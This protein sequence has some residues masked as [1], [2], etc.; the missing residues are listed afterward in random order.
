MDC[1]KAQE[2]I[3]EYVLDPQSLG[4]GGRREIERHVASCRECKKVLR[5]VGLIVSAIRDDG[6]IHPMREESP[7]TQFGNR[8]RKCAA[9][10][11]ML[12]LIAGLTVL[13]DTWARMGERVQKLPVSNGTV[14]ETRSGIIRLEGG[15]TLVAKAGADFAVTPLE[16][17]GGQGHLVNLK[18][19]EL[20]IEVNHNGKPFDVVTSNARAVITGTRFDIRSEG[21]RTELVLVDGEVKFSGGGGMVLVREGRMSAVSGRSGPSAPRAVDSRACV[22]WAY[23]AL[24]RKALAYVNARPEWALLHALPDSLPASVPMDPASLEY[25]AWRD[26]HRAWFQCHFPW[27]FQAESSLNANA[28]FEGDYLDLLMV[29]GD[30]LQFRR[31]AEGER[32]IAVFDPESIRRLGEFYGVPEA[33]IRATPDEFGLHHRTVAAADF[34]QDWMKSLIE[35][36]YLS[37]TRTALFLWMREKCD[38]PKM[39]PI[40]QELAQWASQAPSGKVFEANIVAFLGARAAEANDA[41]GAAL[42]SLVAGADNTLCAPVQ[43]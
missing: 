23:E 12:T 20:Y 16:R 13:M 35:A 34:Q 2:E 22:A 4:R 17:D 27:I 19:G 36:D 14:Q 18:Q 29:S 37:N 41:Y 9:I 6:T 38:E 7:N 39:R 30:I 25:E 10:A 40:V 31:P 24:Q 42:R 15:H 3:V 26:A 21:E 8:A 32:I 1:G 11:A 33:R 28:G 43:R 5:D